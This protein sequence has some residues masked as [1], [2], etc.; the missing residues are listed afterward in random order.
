MQSHRQ[1]ERTFVAPRPWRDPA[2]WSAVVGPIVGFGFVA[3]FAHA[4]VLGVSR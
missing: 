1:R 2:I 4:I 3:Y